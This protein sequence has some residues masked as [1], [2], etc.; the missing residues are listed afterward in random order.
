MVGF[1]SAGKF[2]RLDFRVGYSTAPVSSSELGVTIGLY[3]VVWGASCELLRDG[4]GVGD[5]EEGISWVVS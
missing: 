5:G 2:A 1:L 4:N 3:F